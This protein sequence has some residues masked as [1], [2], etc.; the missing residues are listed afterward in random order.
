MLEMVV[1][2]L[3]LGMIAAVASSQI[4]DTANDARKNSS[5]QSLD[6]IR[7]AIDLY[8]QKNGAYPG[9]SGRGNDF[10]KEVRTMIRTP[11]PTCLVGNKNDR[12]HVER[13]A[14]ALAPGGPKGW[15]YSRVTGEFIINHSDYATW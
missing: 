2:V 4:F 5:R 12:V 11:F 14:G 7:N 9:Q 8:Y 15:R 6:V 13:N 1:V 10:K 3:I